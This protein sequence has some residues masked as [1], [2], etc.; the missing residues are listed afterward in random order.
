[1]NILLYCSI[2]FYFY[3]KKKEKVNETNRK[4]LGPRRESMRKK[5]GHWFAIPDQTLM[6]K[7]RHP[8]RV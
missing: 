5:L 3:L 4:L 7:L 6:T 2:F 1:M 8:N